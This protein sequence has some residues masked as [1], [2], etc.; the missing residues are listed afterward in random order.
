MAE[1]EVPAWDLKAGHQMPSLADLQVPVLPIWIAG[2][3]GALGLGLPLPGIAPAPPAEADVERLLI[4]FLRL[5]DHA[6]VQAR[7]ARAA[8]DRACEA[9]QHDDYPLSSM[10]GLLD[11]A[12]HLESCVNAIYRAVNKFGEPL[13]RCREV[14]AFPRRLDV[15]RGDSGAILSNLRHGIQHMDERIR[16]GRTR[17]WRHPLN[18]LPSQDRLIGPMGAL[19]YTRL[20]RWLEELVLVS[21]ILVEGP[22]G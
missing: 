4:N 12:G 3:I 8:L 2:R 14:P 13:R 20:A 6:V 11:A 16:E 5:V 19:T 22:Y 17:A 18:F 21:W 15:F 1:R 9:E 10:A 7:L